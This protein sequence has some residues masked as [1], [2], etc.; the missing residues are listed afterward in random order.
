MPVTLLARALGGH[1]EPLMLHSRATVADAKAR[2]R[3]AH[4]R[5]P[6]PEITLVGP[7][8]AVLEDDMPL[9]HL[10]AWFKLDDVLS[11]AACKNINFEVE[12]SVLFRA[13]MCARCG[14]TA[15]KSCSG[16]RRVRYCGRQ[17]QKEDWQVHRQGCQ[18]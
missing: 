17:C 18:V 15:S 6:A 9:V 11:P 3:G 10:C 16:C 13:K 1:E 2:L 7:G 8:G 4:P 12:V 5:W 14:A